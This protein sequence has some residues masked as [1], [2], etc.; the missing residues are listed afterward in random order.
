MTWMIEGS[1][2]GHRD[3]RIT[4]RHFTTSRREATSAKDLGYGIRYTDGTTLILTVTQCPPY[5]RRLP[6]I[7]AYN[8]LIADCRHYGVNSVDD[9]IKARAQAK[10][11]KD[12]PSQ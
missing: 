10:L 2:S 4:H 12:K 1:W 5:K 6:V 7:N 9:L 8:T 11:N 3:G